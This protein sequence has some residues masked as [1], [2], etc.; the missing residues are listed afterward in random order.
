[1]QPGEISVV[2][3]ID[4]KTPIRLGLVITLV[5]L[6]F[7]AGIAH[8]RQNATQEQVSELKAVAQR[9]SEKNAAQDVAVQRLEGKMDALLEKVEDIRDAT[10]SRRRAITR[11]EP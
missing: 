7:L 9:N 11:D 1:M 2:Q 10:R 5:G 6:G 8:L 3:A 4:E